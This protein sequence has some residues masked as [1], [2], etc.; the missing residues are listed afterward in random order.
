MVENFEHITRNLS[1]DEKMLIPVLMN[2]FKKKTKTNPV[3]APEVV[4]NLN[5][6]YGRKVLSQPRLRKLCNLLRSTG[7]LP[8]I[9]TSK[10]Y[11][12]SY[13]PEEIKSQIRS[14]KDRANAILA[15]AEGLEKWIQ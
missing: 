8:L 4:K 10:G 5:D 12:V 6:W 2:G 11:Y 7:M 15:S 3:K 9:A 14:L 13:E 1:K